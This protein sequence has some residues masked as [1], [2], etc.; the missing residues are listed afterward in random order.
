[1]SVCCFSL[2]LCPKRHTLKKSSDQTLVLLDGFQVCMIVRVG[3]NQGPSR[4]VEHK[5]GLH[6]KAPNI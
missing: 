5:K 1:M 2:M 4:E 3:V 6:Y